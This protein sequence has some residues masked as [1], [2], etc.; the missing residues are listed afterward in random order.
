MLNSNTWNLF[1]CVQTNEWYSIELL[2]L[3][4]N[5]WIYLIV[6]RQ[7]INNKLN[8]MRLIDIFETI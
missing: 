7:I 8:Y 6:Y 4:T 2:V 1:N 5:T 3:V